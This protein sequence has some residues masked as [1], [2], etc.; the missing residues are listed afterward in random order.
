M[1]VLCLQAFMVLCVVN[2]IVCY[3]PCNRMIKGW[4]TW[5]ICDKINHGYQMKDV[6]D[7]RVQGAQNKRKNV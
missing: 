3:M 5:W 6:F 7:I 4:C 2:Y 1:F